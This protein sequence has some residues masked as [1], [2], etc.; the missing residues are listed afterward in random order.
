[1]N[2][3]GSTNSRINQRFF[4]FSTTP[5]NS[6]YLAP[7]VSAS[8]P[9]NFQIASGGLFQM[10]GYGSN[11][12]NAGTLIPTNDWH[13]LA[14]TV[15]ADTDT[16]R[17]YLDGQQVGERTG[18]T[19]TPS[20][21]GWTTNNWL[22]RSE[23]PVQ[24]RPYWGYLD[25]FRIYDKVLSE[26]EI[27]K[28]M[29]RLTATD[30]RPRNRAAGVGESSVLTWVA[31]DKAVKH[32]V[33]FGTDANAVAYADTS[34]YRGRQPA[35]SYTPTEFPY[36]WGRTYYWRIDEINEA[37]PEGLWRGNV[38]SF[39]VANYLIIDE[40]EDYNN[41]PPDRVFET[42]IDGYDN[43]TVNGSLVGHP[44]PDFAAG[45]DFVETTIFHGGNQSMPYYY[46]CN[47]KYSEAAMTLAG[48]NRDWT[49]H[50]LKSLSI[51]FRGYPATQG[52]FAEGP[53]GTFTITG[54]G[55]DIWTINS[56]EADEFHF[57]WK[58]LSGPGSIT[59]KVNAITGTNLNAWAKAG[60][61]IRET[62]DPNSAHA[63]M[64]LSNTNG[65]AF[66]YRAAAAGTSANA[67][68]KTTISNRPLWLKLDRAFDGTFTASHANDVAGAPDKWTAMTTVNIQMSLNVRIGLALTSHQAYVSAQT[69]FSNVTF[70]G[71]VTGAQWTDQDIGIRSNKAER[72]FVA[73][74]G[75]TGPQAIVYHTDPNAA[76]LNTWTEWNLP[77]TAFAGINLKDVDKISLGFGTKGNAGLGGSGLVYFDDI[78]AYG[79]RCLPALLK[80]AADFDDDCKVNMRDLR[81]MA[82]QWLQ[83]GAALEPDLDQSQ[84]VDFKDY[85]A[86]ADSWL[87]E[88]FWP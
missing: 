84:K 9:T 20:S 66:Q 75:T 49:R 74:Q 62:L 29:V 21:L 40:F 17:L 45:Q 28:V 10:V 86:L 24:Q 57:A 87:T 64:L 78:R 82:I 51:W 41:F 42:W 60:V 61:M 47:M 11:T 69:T 34:V 5:E 4:C 73:I 70:T 52:S 3:L 44:D 65:I 81:L 36:E 88:Q 53:A 76:L 83:T 13:H 7:S 33:Y 6:I 26:A 72:M 32:D 23:S 12:A 55:S 48:L 18:S 19:L 38:W 77:M 8:A 16:F 30:P 80:P 67:Q 15:N 31:G 37:D 71:N 59:A 39:T 54:A 79:P 56:V 46:D 22:G 25:D 43:P 14:V 63:H 58:M 35:T 1:V 85:S 2:W 50:D 27:R 68:Q